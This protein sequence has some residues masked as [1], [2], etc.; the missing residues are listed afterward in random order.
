MA[1]LILVTVLV[2]FGR[3]YFLAGVFRAPLPSMISHIHGA[4]F[5][6]WILLLITQIG[7]VSAGRVDIHRRLGLAGF[8]LACLMV[9]L[10]VLAASNALARGFAPPGSGFDPRTFYAIPIVDMLVFAALVFFA[11]APASIPPPTNA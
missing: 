9:V 2:G 5:S 3:T 8:G 11:T 1:F 4:V 6:S 7:L 10:G